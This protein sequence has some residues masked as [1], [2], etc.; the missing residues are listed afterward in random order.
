[1]GNFPSRRHSG[2]DSGTI[3][4][5]SSAAGRNDGE[6]MSLSDRAD[7]SERIEVNL[8]PRAYPIVVR[9][10]EPGNEGDFVNFVRER[11]ESTWAGRGCRKAL[12]VCDSQVRDLWGAPYAE[13]LRGMGL[14]TEIAEVPSGE[15]SKSPE[16]LLT[17]YD[18]LIDLEAD[19]H[20]LVL[21]V[22]GGVVGDLAGFAAASFNR[23]LP[24][25]MVP[26][27]LL[28]Q[29]DSSVGGKTGINHPH[30]KNLIGAFHQ[31]IGVWIDLESLATLPPREFRSGLAEVLKYGV[32]QDAEF[33]AWLE[34]RADKALAR[35]DAVLVH[36]V[37]RSCRSKADVVEK[38][39]LEHTGL[40]AILNYGHTMA[41]A[42]ENV[43]G[44]GAY[45]HGEAVGAGMVAEARL[46]ARL[47]WI[48]DEVAER[49]ERL[50]RR[51][52]LPATIEGCDEDQL[53]AAMKH[54]KKNRLGRIRFV[55]PR[56]IGEV[57]LTDAPTDDDVRQVLRSMMG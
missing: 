51:L 32:I 6:T 30:G 12:V 49:I 39:E 7:V 9:G 33:F 57:E 42:I 38:D 3:L 37:A 29:V 28:A 24:L 27:T 52:E 20:T 5:D 46:A 55:L 34:T 43:A 14:R 26:T 35:D 23:G 13:R 8:G 40:R 48:D 18:R 53:L 4:S 41:H 45:L 16:T 36:L 17:L 2:D 19:R 54:D 44:Y 31:P 11:L 10:G 47:G 25:I 15:T 50:V 21:A 1:M 22:G 56:R